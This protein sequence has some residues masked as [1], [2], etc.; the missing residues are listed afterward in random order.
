MHVQ[1]FVRLAFNDDIDVVPSKPIKRV[2]WQLTF[3]VDHGLQ[4]SDYRVLLGDTSGNDNCSY[5]LGDQLVDV[6]TWRRIPSFLF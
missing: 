5:Q 3:H 2:S 4:D 1:N 6:A